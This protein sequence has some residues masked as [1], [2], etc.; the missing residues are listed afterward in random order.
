MKTF[1]GR[2]LILIFK[3]PKKI[4]PEEDTLLIVKFKNGGIDF[5]TFE[6]E[7]DEDDFDDPT[8]YRNQALE[9]G[10]FSISRCSNCEDEAD[11]QFDDKVQYSVNQIDSYADCSILI[12]HK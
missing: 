12:E 10:Y 3:D 11:D 9:E 2:E 6:T 1:A 5:A 7:T 8:E 4:L